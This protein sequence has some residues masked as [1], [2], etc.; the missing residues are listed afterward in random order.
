M[1]ITTI[2]GTVSPLRRGDSSLDR[3]RA[4]VERMSDAGSFPL[5]LAVTDMTENAWRCEIDCADGAPLPRLPS[6]FAFRRRRWQR[7]NAFNAVLL[8]PTGIDCSVGGHAGDATPAARLI[9][10]VCD[11]LILHPNVVNASDVNEQ[12]EN[13]LYVEGSLICRLL[14]G[15]IALLRVRQN[16]LLVVTEARDDGPWA[17][18]QVVNTASAARA[19]LGVTCVKVAVL[20]RGLSM[21][22]KTSPSSRAVGEVAGLEGLF[23]LL[24]AERPHY[25]AVALATKIAPLGDAREMFERYYSGEGPNP[26]GGVEATLTHAVS[27]AF[28]VP[29][30]HAPTMEDLA[31]RTFAYGR[32]DPRKAAEAISTSYMFCLLK[33]LHRAPAVIES[34]D[35]VHDPSVIAAEDVSCL[36]V[37]DGC[38]GVPTLAALLQGINVVAVRQNTSLMKND[39]SRLPFASGKLWYVDSYLEAAGVVAALKAGIDPS[40]LR[41]PLSSTLVS[42]H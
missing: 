22:M 4:D 20:R 31:L 15:D 10:S 35:G 3:L 27:S 29:S 5:R 36:I 2:T 1:R 12:P 23:E 6:I 21:S 9:A 39:L 33:G 19:T 40:S 37:P 32:V 26:W 11:H 13:G 17:V 34:P 24:R 30:A 16:R 42:E 14:M 18:D 8:V 38:V 7:A 28:A 41:R 25:D